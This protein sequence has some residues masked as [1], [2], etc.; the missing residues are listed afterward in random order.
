MTTVGVIGNGFVGNAIVQAMKKRTIAVN[1]FDID[2]TKCFSSLRDAIESEIVFI[3]VPA[4]TNLESG[5]TDLTY[6]TT[7]ISQIPQNHM[8]P[9][10]LKSTILPGSCRE[11][12]RFRP[13]LDIVFSP[14]FLTE[15]TAVMDF[16]H[17]SRIILGYKTKPLHHTKDE[18][19]IFFKKC[20]P[21]TYLLCTSWEA[22]EFIKYF[23]NCFYAAKVS[24]MN[25]FFQLSQKLDLD[26]GDCVE[27]LLTSQWVNRMH[28]Q[29]PGPDGDFGFGGKCFPK[30]ILAFI[31]FSKNNGINPLM[32]SS[33]WEK[34]IEVRTNKNWK[35]IEGAFTKGKNNGN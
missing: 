23:C 27:G 17:P 3:C 2:P 18:V 13:D 11:I 10:I 15:R 34:N 16:E 14:E 28:T 7:I 12:S 35:H 6:I 24:L 25:E 8:S 33:A 29:V 31:T 21:D 9:I 22:A 4:P 5:E 26:W 32:L 19:F 1:V 30:D 20:F